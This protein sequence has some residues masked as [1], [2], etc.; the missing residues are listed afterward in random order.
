MVDLLFYSQIL[1]LF[2]KAY[3]KDDSVHVDVKS[4]YQ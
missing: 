2:I 4:N 1:F 3:E